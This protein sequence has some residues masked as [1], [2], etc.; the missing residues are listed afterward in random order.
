MKQYGDHLF[1]E[2]E[3][4]VSA[5]QD[6]VANVN[7]TCSLLDFEASIQAVNL[8][9]GKYQEQPTL[10]DP[11]LG[12]LLKP[13]AAHS[14][15]CAEDA[16]LIVYFHTCNPDLLTEKRALLLTVIY[17]LCKVRGAKIVSR[18]LPQDV[19]YLEPVLG[20]LEAHD[21]NEGHKWEVA[22]VLLVW[23]SIIVL[24]PFELESVDS[25]EAS[26]RSSGGATVSLTERLINRCQSYLRT[27]TKLKDGGAAVL[28]KL[29]SRPDIHQVRE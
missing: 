7:S 17:M 16:S 9:L 24:V 28:A 15:T 4:V 12:E 6:C 13:L 26:S 10:L 25:N 22:Y 29:F 11:L 8:V 27:S 3:R 2:G 1:K 20:A 19:G 23:M 21:A 18:F 5:V 14:R